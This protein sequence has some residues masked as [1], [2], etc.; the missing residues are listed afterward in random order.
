MAAK[1]MLMAVTLTTA[2]TNSAMDLIQDQRDGLWEFACAPDS[3]LTKASE[4]QGLHCKRVNLHQGYDLYQPATWERLAHERKVKRPKRLWFSLPCTKWCPWTRLNYQGPE[5]QELLESYRRRGRRMLGYAARF[6]KDALEED[7]ETFVYW[8]WP[9][10]CLGWHQRA[11]QDL[12]AYMEEQCIP[13]Q[14]CRIDGCRYDLK[15]I[16]GTGFIHKKW[17]INT[18][19]EGFWS[20]FKAKTCCSIHQHVSITGQETSRSAFYPWKMVEA[21]SRFWKSQMVNA[22]RSRYIMA[23]EDVNSLDFINENDI[24]AA[25]N[26][27]DPEQDQAIAAPSSSSQS[28]AMAL[29]PSRQEAERWTARVAHYHKAAGHPTVRNTVRLLRDSGQPLWKIRIA[30]NFKCPACESLKPGGSSSGGVPPAATHELPQAWTTVGIDVFDWTVPGQKK[31]VKGLLMLDMA[32]KLRV[33]V[34]VMP[35]FELLVMKTETAQQIIKAFCEG[36]LAHY[37]KPLQLIPDNGRAFGSEEFTKFCQDNGIVVNF[38]AEKEAWSHGVVEHAIKDLKH[39][40]S[41]IQLEAMDQDPMVTLVLAASGYTSHQWAFGKDHSLLDEDYMTFNQI[42][43][44]LSYSKL[45]SARHQAEQVARKHRAGR[46]LMRLSNSKARQPLR[47]Y[48]CTDLVK[49]WRRVHPELEG[50]RGGTRKSQRPGWI[51]PGRVIFSEA[52][53]HQDPQDHRKHVVWVLMQGKLFRCSA[54]SVRP[55]T[56]PERLRWEVTSK[57]DISQW[58]TLADIMPKKEHQDL[59]DEIPAENE[60]E[61]PNLP[62]HP[63]STTYAPIRRQTTKS[64]LAPEDY[65]VVHRSSPLGLEKKS[66]VPLGFDRPLDSRPSS[67]AG[68]DSGLSGPTASGLGA[69]DDQHPPGFGEDEV[70]VNEYE[71]TEPDTAPEPASK[72]ARGEEDDLLHLSWVEK[73]QVDAALEEQAFSLNQLVRENEDILTVTFEV[74]ATSHRQR[75]FLERNPVAY[76]IKKMNSS[77]VNISKLTP[78][79]QRLF[80]HAK[81]KE[82]SS[83]IKNEAVR[84]CLSSEE[85]K[86]AYDSNRILKARWILVWKAIPEEERQE[87]LDDLANNPNTTVTPDAKQKAKARIVLLGF[88]HPSLLDRSFKTSAPVTSMIGR[89]IIYLL[90]SHHQW[91]LEGLDLAT[92]F[93]QTQPTEADANLWTTG[94]A[95]L[96]EALG[97]GQEG[98]LKVL[99]NIYGSTT[100]PRGLWLDLHRTLVKLGG[101]AVLGERSMWAWFSTTET[102]VTGRYPKLLGCM[103]GHVDDFNR[104]GDN[105]SQEWRDMCTRIDAAYKWGTARRRDYRHA[106][107]DVRTK[108]YKDGKFM[109]TVH[110]DAYVEALPDLDIPAERLRQE[111]K[112]TPREVAAC[113]TTL[114]GLQ[115]LAI[116]T[117]PLLCSRCNIL[118]TE[119][120]VNG[121][122][123]EAREIQSM[124]GEVRRQPSHLRF[125]PLDGAKKW[126][127]IVFISMGDQAHANRPK[128]EARSL[129]CAC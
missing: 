113:R 121:T 81:N 75:K 96:C 28:E 99:R 24:M 84:K 106:G 19:D 6:I 41:A 59:T 116:Q 125:F 23:K 129:L 83:F 126:N 44:K 15:S 67:S 46:I 109:V 69:G 26:A 32:T 86:Q 55:V 61:H 88:Q 97:V 79:L 107:T 68:L 16:D 39:T 35:P 127:D 27:E 105:T 72:R 43:D 115:W 102:D 64:T 104:I 54:L 47:D 2:L 123:S 34:P 9:K 8:E 85:I 128:G 48:K 112:L 52:L 119:V 101:Q 70:S 111:G 21:I 100:A 77:E 5:R 65:R 49:I 89:N 56:E 38:P 80:T 73:L 53:P 117:Q 110:Q 62:W 10:E 29:P 7:P 25:E 11:L 74:E 20:R 114:G 87:A 31:K 37:P 76:M 51:G 3:W 103:G 93:L 40:A 1:V 58:K 98:I 4:R 95:E 94:V 92:A 78:A 122:L 42:K 50:P 14:Q 22:Q 124:V 30:E 108:P 82:V 18:T 90:A 17:R 36:W 60:P 33:V 63:D 71:P 13:W 57:E 91:E 120:T 118:L 12:Q 45:V 66:I